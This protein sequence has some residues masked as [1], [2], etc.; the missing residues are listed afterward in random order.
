VRVA[1]RIRFDSGLILE[2]DAGLFY[3]VEPQRDLYQGRFCSGLTAVS[4]SVQMRP[5]AHFFS[6][7]L[8]SDFFVPRASESV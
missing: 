7:L 5:I 2:L 3:V 1:G 6:L 8:V 4:V